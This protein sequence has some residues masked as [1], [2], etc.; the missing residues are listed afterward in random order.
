M[1]GS[2]KASIHAYG[3]A[4]DFA[5]E[6]NLLSDKGN[7]A[8]FNQPPYSAFFDILEKHGWHNQ[9]R[10]KDNDYMHFQAVVY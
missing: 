6:L 9:G 1:R 2:T 7:N 5:A 3:C 10:N 8:L 4:V